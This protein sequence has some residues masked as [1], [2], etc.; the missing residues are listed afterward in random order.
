LTAYLSHHPRA[1]E[2]ANRQRGD[3]LSAK[4][5]NEEPLSTEKDA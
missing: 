1:D 4:S 3:E 5:V 2:P